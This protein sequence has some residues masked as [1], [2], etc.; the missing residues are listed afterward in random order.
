[1]RKLHNLLHFMVIIVLQLSLR[2]STLVSANI[3]IS[4]GLLQIAGVPK[5]VLHIAGVPKVALEIAG[6]QI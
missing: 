3:S 1:M 4:S 5:V 2:Q 6:V